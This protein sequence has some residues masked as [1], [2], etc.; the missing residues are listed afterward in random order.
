MADQIRYAEYNDTARTV[1]TRDMV[2]TVIEQRPYT[3]EENAEADARDNATVNEETLR[4]NTTTA[5][6]TLSQVVTDLQSIATKV[7]TAITPADTKLIAAD[8]V[9][10]VRQ[11][12]RVSR[13]QVN[14]YD[15]A[16]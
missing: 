1:T 2:G 14:Q 11:V 10:V 13:L 4:S 5:I 7:D 16:L 8:L 6:A 15:S 9:K 12:V 3:D